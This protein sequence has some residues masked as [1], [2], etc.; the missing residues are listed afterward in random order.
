MIRKV[1]EKI[2]RILIVSLFDNIC[3]RLLEC[4]NFV[5]YIEIGFVDHKYRR[6]SLFLTNNVSDYIK[7]SLV[8]IE[9]EVLFL[10]VNVHFV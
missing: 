2:I 3:E 4:Y 7:R 10:T 1:T 5:D 6:I 8:I 9:Y